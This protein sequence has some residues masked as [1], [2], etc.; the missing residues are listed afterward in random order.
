[1]AASSTYSG[2]FSVDAAALLVSSNFLS[3]LALKDPLE[4]S[5][6]RDFVSPSIFYLP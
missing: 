4:I 2:R 5:D 1:M 6:K 3:A